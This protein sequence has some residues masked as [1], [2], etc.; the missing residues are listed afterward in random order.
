MPRV[1][2][3]S[4]MAGVVDDHV[5]TALFRA[6]PFVYQQYQYH[7]RTGLDKAIVIREA[8]CHWRHTRQST[9]DSRV[10]VGSTT[11]LKIDG[12]CLSANLYLGRRAA[13]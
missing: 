12:L 10:P 11:R 1:G 8:P 4:K 7:S 2:Y 13:R 3:A 9:F 6:R 5:L